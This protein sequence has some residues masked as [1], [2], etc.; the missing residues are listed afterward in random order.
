MGLPDT[1]WDC[2]RTAD[3]ARG[4]A[5]GVNGAAYMAVPWSVLVTGIY[6]TDPSGP[7]FRPDR[8]A[9]CDRPMERLGYSR[10]V[11]LCTFH[12]PPMRTRLPRLG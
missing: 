8:Y 11:C 7:E 2:H 5:R 9:V 1:S 10:L 6:Y 4:G 12:L 3:Q